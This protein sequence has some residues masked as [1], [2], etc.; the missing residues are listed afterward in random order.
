MN[1]DREPTLHNRERFY[2]ASLQ[3]VTL[4]VFPSGVC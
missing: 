4:T 1:G 3:A 2:L